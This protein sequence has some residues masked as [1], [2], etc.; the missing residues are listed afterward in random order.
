MA[1]ASKS[2]PEQSKSSETST[3]SFEFSRRTANQKKTK[4][5]VRKIPQFVTED[6]IKSHLSE[7]TDAYDW[8][9]FTCQPQEPN[10]T[11]RTKTNFNRFYINFKSFPDSILF[12]EK[13]QKLTFQKPE[14]EEKKD[15]KKPKTEKE[16]EKE[17][18]KDF[19]AQYNKPKVAPIYRLQVEFSPNQSLPIAITAHDKRI[20]TIEKDKDYISF[21]ESLE[22]KKQ[23][24]KEIVKK[25]EESLI[26]RNVIS[27]SKKVK[28]D[29][30]KKQDKNEKKEEQ[31]IAP[32]A[33]HVATKRHRRQL[34]K[35][36][37]RASL[38]KKEKLKAKE[39]ERIREM[40]RRK[41]IALA[42]AAKYGKKQWI[43]KKEK[44]KVKVKEKGS[45]NNNDD[46]NDRRDMRDDRDDR[47]D[48][49]YYKDWDYEYDSVKRRPVYG[50][51]S[52]KKRYNRRGRGRGRGG[53]GR[54]GYVG[55]DDHFS[56]YTRRKGAQTWKAK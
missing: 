30:D 18:E 23:Q 26:R 8:F 36:I 54:G 5:V 1:T 32:L 42:K 33:K 15:N 2:S 6:E 19:W 56:G 55:V 3:D 43:A 27:L 25:A 34:Y 40:R 35:K 17:K 29:D 11:R 37:D 22:T 39:I 51:N 46:R 41:R 10:P 14:P 52:G 48:R 20:G 44:E 21:C 9:Y 13:F 7:F 28:K 50:N 45:E 38:I 49:Q 31:I 24:V 53:R 4:F 47:D 16:K 12:I